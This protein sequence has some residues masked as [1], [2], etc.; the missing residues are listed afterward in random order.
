[1]QVVAPYLRDRDAVRAAG[2]IAEIA[3]GYD[4]PPGF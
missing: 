1:M 3:G 4:P 2:L